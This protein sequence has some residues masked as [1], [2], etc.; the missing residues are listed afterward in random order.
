MT[1]PDVR[2]SGLYRVS[3]PRTITN[4]TIIIQQDCHI[5]ISSYSGQLQVQ[6]PNPNQT[7]MPENAI[8]YSYKLRL[9]DYHLHLAAAVHV[10]D[11][12]S[13]ISLF[14]HGKSAPCLPV[15][16]ENVPVHGDPICP[17]P[18]LSRANALG[19]FHKVCPL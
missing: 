2:C 12:R 17:T 9:R 14:N 11:I 15:M 6:A 4:K 3:S 13:R 8:F 16:T 18:A 5:L 19:R 1:L 10:K 7:R